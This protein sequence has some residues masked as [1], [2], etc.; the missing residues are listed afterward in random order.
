[1]E[2]SK[3]YLNAHWSKDDNGKREFFII[4]E[5]II[6]K[7]CIL[8]ENIEPCFEGA[9]IE[10]PKIEFSFEE[11]FKQELFSMISEIKNILNEGGK[12]MYTTYAVEIGDSL[13]SALYEYLL[14]KYPDEE[15][16]YCS[17]YRIE[18]IYEEGEQKFAILQSH[19]STPE[20]YRLNFTLT[21]QDGFTAEEELVNVA[22]TFQPAE[23]PQFALE[24]YEAYV[25]TYA[26]NK[27][28]E[29]K[30]KEEICPECGKPVGECECNKKQY[31]LEEIPEYVELLNQCN[32]LQN[33]INAITAESE[34]LTAELTTLKEFKAG[35]E[36][37]EKQEMINSFYM[38]S[39]ED[40]KDV[41]ENIDSYS[42]S[43]I[44]AKLSILCVRNKVSFDLDKNNDQEPLTYNLD[45]QNSS[46]NNIPE[47]VKAIQEYVAEN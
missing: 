30:G 43:D 37:K 35:V 47:W 41:T 9:S 17:K 42:L 44:E 22:K 13:W 11:G 46:N 2:L 28:A 40:K 19:N 25:S 26:E 7:L 18:G 4:N 15:N 12:T 16:G 27:K 1:M 29:E 14:K 6:S 39:D 20:Y 5:A 31:N 3:E 45:S 32:E 33:K 23:T 8:G 10:A 34:A 36:K 21:E 24:D 38:L